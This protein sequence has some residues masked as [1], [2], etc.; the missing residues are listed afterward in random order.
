[1]AVLAAAG[2]LAAGCSDSATERT[3]AAPPRHA[4]FANAPLVGR[5]DG[6]VHLLSIRGMGSFSV[7]CAR[8]LPKVGFRAGG[9][10]TLHATVDGT[11]RVRSA[12]LDPGQGLA[13]R[14]KGGVLVQHWQL[15]VA[16]EAQA[17]VATVSISAARATAV[18]NLGCQASGHATVDRRR[19]TNRAPSG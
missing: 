11:G 17:D 8:G 12:F 18:G 16:T 6:S 9:A 1:V 15:G 4:S 19:R 2:V 13:P 3:G 7:S 5:G 14:A 10:A